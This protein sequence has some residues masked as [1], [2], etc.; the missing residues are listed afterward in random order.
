M[1]PRLRL[2]CLAIAFIL[3]AQGAWR[4]GQALGQELPAGT[5]RDDVEAL[6]GGCHSLQLVTQQGL[7]REVWAEVILYMVEEQEMPELDPEEEQLVLD[8][9]AHFYGPDRLAERSAGQ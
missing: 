8:Y 5:G 6:C 1:T 4:P 7:S 2:A 9:L 3:L